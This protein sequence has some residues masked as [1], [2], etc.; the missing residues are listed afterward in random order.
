MP[1]AMLLLT[2]GAH[3]WPGG[4]ATVTVSHPYARSRRATG[5]LFYGPCRH[6]SAAGSPHLITADTVR[7]ETAVID[8]GKNRLQDPLTANPKWVGHVDCDGVG[9]KASCLT[10]LPGGVSPIIVV[11]LMKNAIIDAKRVLRLE[12]QGL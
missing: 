5:C 1:I 4:G 6:C 7:E 10:L 8:A 3:E 2:G 11:L 12:E 9:K